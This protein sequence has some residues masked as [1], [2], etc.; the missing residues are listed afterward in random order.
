LGVKK[1]KRKDLVEIWEIP[2]IENEF[3]LGIGQ[4]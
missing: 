2:S 4:S 1:K 3:F